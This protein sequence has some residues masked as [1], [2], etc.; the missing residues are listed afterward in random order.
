VAIRVSE[1]HEPEEGDDA[2]YES[3][4]EMLKSLELANVALVAGEPGYRRQVRAS[5]D[6][7]FG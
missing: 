3:H 6:L 7:S 5:C 4:C 2:G 1:Q